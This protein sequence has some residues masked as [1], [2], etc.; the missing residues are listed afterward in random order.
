MRHLYLKIRRLV[1]ADIRDNSRPAS[2]LLGF[3]LVMPPVIG[4]LP[5]SGF[6][7]ISIWTVFGA[8]AL[9]WTGF[10]WWRVA[11][12]ARASVLRGDRNYDQRVK[13]ELARE[14]AETESATASQRRRKRARRGG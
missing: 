1:D 7:G 12:I 11:R 13:Y 3:V 5:F 8:V 9:A 14:Y 4:G 6:F 10:A 2:P